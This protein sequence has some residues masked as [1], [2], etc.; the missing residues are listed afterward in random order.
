MHQLNRNYLETLKKR[1]YDVASEAMEGCNKINKCLKP[2]V[3]E[4]LTLQVFVTSCFVLLCLRLFCP[5]VFANWCATLEF[6]EYLVPNKNMI[7]KW[8]SGQNLFNSLAS[9]IV[10]TKWKVWLIWLQEI[11]RKYRLEYKQDFDMLSEY[12]NNLEQ[13]RSHMFASVSELASHINSVSSPPLSFTY[14]AV[15]VGL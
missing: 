11:L 15:F 7:L 2:R 13:W 6:L 3:Q 12:E 9:I 1:A 14:S 8:K 5:G 10:V 4:F